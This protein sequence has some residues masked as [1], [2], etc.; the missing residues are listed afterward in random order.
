MW[1]LEVLFEI[2]WIPNL[3]QTL[4]A[5]IDIAAYSLQLDEI[6]SPDLI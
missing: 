1:I 4:A 2:Y 3:K 5:Y 6:R